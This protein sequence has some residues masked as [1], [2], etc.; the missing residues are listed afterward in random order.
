MTP[1]KDG[2]MILGCV[3]LFFILLFVAAFAGKGRD[4]MTDDFERN[5]III[6]LLRTLPAEYVERLRHVPL[7]PIADTGTWL[8]ERNGTIYLVACPGIVLYDPG[9]EKKK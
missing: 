3:L 4:L 2:L 9:K 7:G 8:C 1:I 5:Q 6:E